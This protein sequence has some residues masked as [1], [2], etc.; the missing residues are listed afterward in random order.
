M[1]TNVPNLIVVTGTPG[2][3]K[4]TLAHKLA[5]EIGCPAICRDEIKE[6]YV[7][8]QNKSHDE[9]GDGVNAEIYDVF[10]EIVDI[11]L[12]YGITVVIEAAFQHKVWVPRL[13]EIKNVAKLKLL[14][15]DVDPSV[16]LKRRQRRLLAKPNREKFHGENMKDIF[17]G[18]HAVQIY[19]P[20]SLDVPILR[21][22]TTNEYDPKF[23]TILHFIMGERG[24]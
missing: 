9:L 8:T 11:Y 5:K 20:P 21:V 2:S 19:D 6:G 1:N 24:Q 22:N 17:G 7:I 3:G 18:V 23:E 4:T 15:C 13:N 12:R 10:F 16:A 14:I